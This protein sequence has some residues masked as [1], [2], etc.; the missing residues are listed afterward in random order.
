MYFTL[1]FT[2]LYR[3]KFKLGCVTKT[4]DDAVYRT[5]G[6]RTGGV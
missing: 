6:D 1:C 4:L 3:Q 2:G 5:R